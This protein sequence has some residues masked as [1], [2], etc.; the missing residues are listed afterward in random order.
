MKTV[1]F[2]FLL[3]ISISTKSQH[4]LDTSKIWSVLECSTGG[5][6]SC[7]TIKYKLEEDTIINSLKYFQMHAS[8]DSLGTNWYPVQYI[9]S[10]DTISKK[11]FVNNILL[12][13]FTLNKGDTIQAAGPFG[14]SFCH[15][16]VVDSVDTFVYSGTARRRIL[17]EYNVS[18]YTTT[19]IEGFGSTDGIIHSFIRTCMVDA[20]AN[21]LCCDSAGTL[22]YQSTYFTSCFITLSNVE[23]EKLSS[24]MVSPNPFYDRIKINF[25]QTFGKEILLKIFNLPGELILENTIREGDQEIMLP[26]LVCGMYYLLLQNDEFVFVKKLV[27]TY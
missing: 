23:P 7:S 26:P 15:S 5:G 17:F 2:T 3:F 6:T 22:I 1:V 11:V 19:W 12:Y 27:K 9:L 10:E 25:Q 20:D 24:V 21:L 16:Y 13:D 4:F 18:Q 8:D 14:S